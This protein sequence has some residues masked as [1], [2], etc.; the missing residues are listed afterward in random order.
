MVIQQLTLKI[1]KLTH[2]LRLVLKTQ[3]IN[4]DKNYNS[5]IHKKITYKVALELDNINKL[6]INLIKLLKTL[7]VS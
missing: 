1:T 5:F 7:S 6:R 2:Q 4:S 3:N